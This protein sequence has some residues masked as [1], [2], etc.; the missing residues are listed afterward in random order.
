MKIKRIVTK[1]FIIIAIAA[2]FTMLSVVSG[3]RAGKKQIP[4]PVVENALIG[5]SMAYDGKYFWATQVPRLSHLEEDRKIIQFDDSGT[6]INSYAPEEN[7]HDVT[8]DGEHLWT[9]T[10]FGWEAGRYYG[11]H[12]YFYTID[13]E[14]GEL[15]PQFMISQVYDWL[16]G[17]TAGEGRLW[18]AVKIEH[19]MFLFEIDPTLGVVVNT[20]QL[21]D[22]S[23]TAIAYA[24]NYLW[25][26]GGFLKHEVVKINPHTGEVIKEF[27]YTG[28]ILNGIVAVDNDIF[29][30]DGEKNVLFK[31]KE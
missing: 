30:V 16:E 19:A 28:R 17:L 8:F 11:E 9:A 15:T 21:P 27:D 31:H 13:P 24:K 7:F 23:V 26:A 1:I 22:I 4:M 25:V 2:M 18:A 29:L 12:G 6:L 5:G 14:T 20:I 10:V 3:C